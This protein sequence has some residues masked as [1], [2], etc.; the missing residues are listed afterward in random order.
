MSFLIDPGLLENIGYNWCVPR[1]R[2][3][4]IEE[5]GIEIRDKGPRIYQHLT[6]TDADT[7]SQPPHFA[8][9]PQWKS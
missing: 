8:W 7:H 2:N 5:E 4:R 1:V 6:N 3:G 9:G